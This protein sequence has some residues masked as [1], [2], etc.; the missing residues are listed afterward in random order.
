MTREPSTD[1]LMRH[2]AD[3]IGDG[4]RLQSQCLDLLLAEMRALALL[5]PAATAASSD[6]ETEAEFDNMPV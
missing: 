2:E 4:L 5:L 3:L 1:E 6:S